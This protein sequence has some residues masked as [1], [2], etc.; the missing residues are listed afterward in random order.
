MGEL[1]G[2]DFGQKIRTA[3]PYEAAH[4]S[5]VIADIKELPGCSG[6]ADIDTARDL[7]E[8]FAAAK[9]KAAKAGEPDPTQ[10]A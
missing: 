9:A 6:D 4:E 8:F 10:F 3:L 1:I 5:R 7:M 2:F